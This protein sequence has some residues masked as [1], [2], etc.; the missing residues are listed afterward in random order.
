MF[1]KLISLLLLFLI[2][3]VATADYDEVYDEVVCLD[4][5]VN[6]KKFKKAYAKWKEPS[7]YSFTF[8]DAALE[9][10]PDVKRVIKNGVSLRKKPYRALLTINDFYKLIKKE[11][12]QGCPENG[13]SYRCHIEYKTDKKTGLVYPWFISI[14][15]DE[16]DVYDHTNYIIENVRF[17]KCG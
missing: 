3:V 2:A 12:I 1:R 15:Y 11:C 8:H 7:C 10:A 6:N 9:Y 17:G 5:Q 13:V 4:W 16:D 14:S